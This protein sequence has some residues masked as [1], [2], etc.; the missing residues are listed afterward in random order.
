MATVWN[1]NSDLQKEQARHQEMLRPF[2]FEH[3][4]LLCDMT[5]ESFPAYSTHLFYFEGTNCIFSISIQLCKTRN[6]G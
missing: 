6:A 4:A 1:N 2:I 5:I 3:K